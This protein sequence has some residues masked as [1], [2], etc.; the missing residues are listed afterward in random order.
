MADDVERIHT[1][2]G[3]VRWLDRYRRFLAI[4]A[5]VIAAPVLTVELGTVLGT[6]WPEMHATLLGLMLG[7]MLWWF[8]EV[9]LVWITAVW[10][11]ECDRLIR[12]R[13]MPPARIVL[14]K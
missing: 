11:T 8:V 4:S 9:A 6:E 7:V 12:D 1:L 5:A 2:A 13:G 3:R 14:R 10:E